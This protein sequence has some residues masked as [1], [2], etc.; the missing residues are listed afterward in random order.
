VSAAHY[1]PP[2]MPDDHAEAVPMLWERHHRAANDLA[3]VTAKVDD[4]AKALIGFDASWRTLKIVG[5]VIAFALGTGAAL[6]GY[7]ATMV[8][9]M[10]EIQTSASAQAAARKAP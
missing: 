8:H 1:D 6:I 10:R 4:H 7:V 5:A 3:S 2:A 9:D